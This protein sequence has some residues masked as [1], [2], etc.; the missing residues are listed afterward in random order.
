MAGAHHVALRQDRAAAQQ[1]DA[2][3]H[4]HLVRGVRDSGNGS[5]DDAALIVAIF[6]NT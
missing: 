1:L 2:H 5:A 3:N 6:E 4:L